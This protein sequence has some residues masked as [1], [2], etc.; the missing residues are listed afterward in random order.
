[1][2]QTRPQSSCHPLRIRNLSSG[3][4]GCGLATAPRK[5][6]SRSRFARPDLAPVRGV[7][8]R[9][10]RPADKLT[11]GSACQK[12][13][14]AKSDKGGWR[15]SRAPLKFREAPVLVMKLSYN[16]KDYLLWAV[17]IAVIAAAYLGLHAIR[18]I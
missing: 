13:T 14:R 15:K 7:G 8:S 2:V 10:L 4:Q 5:E 1:M 12:G 6:P 9:H 11:S 17:I 18:I 3:L 16:P